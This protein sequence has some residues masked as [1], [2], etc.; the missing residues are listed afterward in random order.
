MYINCGYTTGISRRDLSQ[1]PTGF[2]TSCS[3]FIA[4]HFTD[5]GDLSI[6]L[7]HDGIIYGVM[8]VVAPRSH[9]ID[10]EEQ[11]LFKEVADDIALAL[12]SIRLE[13]QRRLA[14]EALQKREAELNL[15]M[16]NTRDMIFAIV[17]SKGMSD[18]F[19][20][21][22]GTARPGFDNFFVPA[23]SVNFTKES[24]VNIRTFFE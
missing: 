12:H 9:I 17:N 20:S 18:H 2:S 15:I 7:E 6:R 21:N 11:G 19:W 22:S 10:E 23:E 1:C 4:D 5:N 3:L 24:L 14:E 16:N 13:E 8:T